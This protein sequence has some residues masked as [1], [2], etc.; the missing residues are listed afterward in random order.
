MYYVEQAPTVSL[1][2]LPRTLLSS[3]IIERDAKNM[4]KDLEVFHTVPVP[5]GFSTRGILYC[6][7]HTRRSGC[8]QL[9]H[10]VLL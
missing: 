7:G 5:S 1:M 4:A 10:H 6:R 2:S 3:R 8:H 9:K